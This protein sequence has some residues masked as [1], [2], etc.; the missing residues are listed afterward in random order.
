MA[1]LKF[2]QR[3]PYNYLKTRFN[4]IQKLVIYVDTIFKPSLYGFDVLY[5]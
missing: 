4:E 1:N 2:F 3:K 5:V